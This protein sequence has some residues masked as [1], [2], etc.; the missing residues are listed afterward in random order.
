M[1]KKM[2]SGELT[3]DKLKNE[4]EGMMGKLSENPMF[5]DIMGQ[6][7]PKQR[8]GQGPDKEVNEPTEEEVNELSKEEKHRR[9]R[10][11]INE[12]RNNR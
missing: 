8:E 4:A 5:S 10:K 12:K 7:N 1:E 3:E 6:M 11:K 9:L 2:E